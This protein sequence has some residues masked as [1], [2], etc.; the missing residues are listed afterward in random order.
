MDPPHSCPLVWSGSD[1]L[2]TR[3][4]LA[5]PG[6]CCLPESAPAGQAGHCQAAP[7]GSSGHPLAAPGA[8]KPPPARCLCPVSLPAITH[9][10]QL[11]GRAGTSRP[12]TLNYWV[13]PLIPSGFGFYYFYYFYFYYWVWPLIPSGFGHLP[14]A[15]VRLPRSCRPI[16]SRSFSIDLLLKKGELTPSPTNAL[17]KT[18]QNKASTFRHLV[19][20][21]IP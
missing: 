16:P 3:R 8:P 21:L 1:C 15:R 14:G 7:G 18:P 9:P 4:T 2:A 19:P 5:T 20:S 10:G 17:G 11:V 13:W 12:A 6:N